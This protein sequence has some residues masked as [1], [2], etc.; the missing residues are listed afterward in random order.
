[1]TMNIQPPKN[2]LGIRPENL[3]QSAFATFGTV[4]ENPDPSVIPSL[5]LR[6]LPA[7]AKQANQGS[8][9][10]YLDVSQL[11]N[12]YD[13]A[14]SKIPARTL[15]SMFVCGPRALLPDQGINVE[16]SFSVEILERH[17]YTTQTFI[18]LGLTPSGEGESRYLVVVAPSLP[19]S[20]EDEA[21]PTPTGMNLPGRGLPDIT[22]IKAFVANGSQAVTYGAGTWHAPMLVV[23][24]KPVDFVVVQFSNGVG[25]EDC[26][27]VQWKAEKGK[28][29][30]VVV[31]KI[32]Q[33]QGLWK[34]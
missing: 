30:M 6:K 29:V 15:M 2:F 24:K 23:G 22:K 19:P 16:G 3:S 1:M 10:Q 9:L 11:T 14:P 7:K 13:L 20:T 25:L 26:Q 33:S 17:P 12:M 18:P 4:I 32:G 21:L 31:P 27:I 34:L 8:A 5:K 28:E